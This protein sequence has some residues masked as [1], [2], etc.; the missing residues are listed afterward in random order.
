MGCV[1]ELTSGYLVENVVGLVEDLVVVGQ[2]VV[3]QVVVRQ[4][5]GSLV[6]GCR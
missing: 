2:I 6:V 5:V 1:G 4:V 3:G